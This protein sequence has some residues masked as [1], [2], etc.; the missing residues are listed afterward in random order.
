MKRRSVFCF[1]F[2]RFGRKVAAFIYVVLL[3]DLVHKS[4]QFIWH[5]FGA[6]RNRIK[7]K[8]VPVALIRK[9]KGK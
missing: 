8:E 7:V 6:A 3:L 4:P 2:V 1:S 5:C 9:R